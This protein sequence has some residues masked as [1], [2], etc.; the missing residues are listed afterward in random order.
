MIIVSSLHYDVVSI[1]WI[2]KDS[3]ATIETEREKIIEEK[4]KPFREFNNELDNLNMVYDSW[5]S[6]LIVKV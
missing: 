3:N 4:G 6:V 5:N 2:T 1:K